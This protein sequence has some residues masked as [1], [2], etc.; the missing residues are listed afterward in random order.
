M[1]KFYLALISIMVLGLKPKTG[2]IPGHT[3]SDSSQLMAQGLSSA[4]LSPFPDDATD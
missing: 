4:Y 2:T 3:L 1:V